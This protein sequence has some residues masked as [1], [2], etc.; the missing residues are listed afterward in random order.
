MP[1]MRALIKKAIVSTSSVLR[2]EASIVKIFSGFTVLS[3]VKLA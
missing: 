1:R 2:L 3:K